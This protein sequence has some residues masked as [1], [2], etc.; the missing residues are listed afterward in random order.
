LASY[1]KFLDVPVVVTEY[2]LAATLSLPSLAC[3]TIV[4]APIARF[5]AASNLNGATPLV[6]ITFAGLPFTVT[7]AGSSTKPENV[8]APWSRSDRS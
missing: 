7:V 4:F 6:D 5:T 2:A 1:S 3:T 8:V